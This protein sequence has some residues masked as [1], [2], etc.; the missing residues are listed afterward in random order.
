MG[1]L[2][3]EGLIKL[4]KYISE[5]MAYRLA[6]PKNEDYFGISGDCA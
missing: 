3:S 5:I 2:G 1:V 4:M 6:T